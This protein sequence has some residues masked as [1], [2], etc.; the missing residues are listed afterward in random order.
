MNPFPNWSRPLHIT[1]LFAVYWSSGSL[2]IYEFVGVFLDHWLKKKVNWYNLEQISV[3][4][5]ETDQCVRYLLT[6]TCVLIPKKQILK[7]I[8]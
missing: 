4:L 7:S 6:Y 3:K 1:E 8:Y 5:L 2:Q